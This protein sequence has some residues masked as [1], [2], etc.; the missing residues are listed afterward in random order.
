MEQTINSEHFNKLYNSRQN[1]I[2]ILGDIGY[3]TSSHELF[4][5]NE[6]YSMIQNEQINFNLKKINQ[7][8]KCKNVQIHYYELLGKTN[9]ALRDKVIDEIIE[10]YYYIQNILGPNDRLIIV[11]ND[12]PNDTIINYLKQM[13]EKNHLLINIISIKRLQ[14]NILKHN[15]VP[16]HRILLDEEKEEFLKGYNIQNLK[17]V[18]EISRFD[19][20]SQV[21]GIR[22]DEICEILRPSKNA[23]NT[24]YYRACVNY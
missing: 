4:S 10:D 16:K 14:F 5:M 6:L 22:P 3:N 15:M 21:I 7:D 13:W 20:V 19:P 11:V 2:E 8:D 18:P 23:I 17:Q 12:D 1:L 9:K 24:K